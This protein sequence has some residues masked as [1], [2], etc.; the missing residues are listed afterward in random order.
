MVACPEV[1]SAYGRDPYMVGSTLSQCRA[2]VGDTLRFG[3]TFS[4]T[5]NPQVTEPCSK[6]ECARGQAWRKNPGFSA[7]VPTMDSSERTA[8]MSSAYTGPEP[9]GHTKSMHGRLNYGARR[10]PA[11]EIQ[12]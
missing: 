12:P 6:V 11:I 3:L 7:G 4:R 5:G 2:G 1:K 8:N 10:A 9:G